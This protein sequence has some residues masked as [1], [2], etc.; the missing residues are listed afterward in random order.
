MSVTGIAA[1]IGAARQRSLD[2]VKLV[3]LQGKQFRS[4]IG[5]REMAR[6]AGAS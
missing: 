5:W 6:G 1:D 4:D 3:K 2:M